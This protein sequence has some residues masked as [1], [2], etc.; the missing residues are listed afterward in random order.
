MLLAPKPKQTILLLIG[1][2]CLTLTASPVTFAA[3]Y[4]HLVANPYAVTGVRKNVDVYL[5][6]DGQTLTAIQAVVNFNSSYLTKDSISILSSRCSFWAPADPALGYGS[7]STP[8]FYGSSKAVLACGF[9]NPGYTSSTSTGAKIATL[10]FTPTA[11]GSANLNFSNVV[12]RYIGST[13]NPGNSSTLD[14]T[15]Y[16]STESANEANPSPTPIPTPGSS[17]STGTTGST[18]IISDPSDTLSESDLQFVQVNGSSGSNRTTSTSGSLDAQ[19]QVIDPDNSIPEAP[20]MTQRPKPTAYVFDPNVAKNQAQDNPGEVLSVQSLR[21]LLIP[22]K[23]EA[24][25]TV[26]MVNFITT[27]AF[28][29]LL[30]IAVWR[31]MNISRMNSLRFKHMS[32]MLTGELS[33]LETKM[34][35]TSDPSKVDLQ[36]SFEDLLTSVN[37]KPK[38]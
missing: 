15:V 36:Q 12:M 1:I 33:V 4:F 8:Y 35:S 29:I 37:E 9:S 14:I 30:A 10:S 28:L 11:S 26:V 27:L 20:A 34:V 2:I 19:L 23:S 32:E 25:R 31:M 18:T 22:G 24:D 13:I 7:N 16:E 6:T 5:A 3:P 38:K 17:G 21:E